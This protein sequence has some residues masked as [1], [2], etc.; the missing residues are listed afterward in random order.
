MAKQTVS[1]A[2]DLIDSMGWATRFPE[3][4]AAFEACETPAQARRLERAVLM[5][6]APFECSAGAA[7]AFKTVV[8]A[9]LTPERVVQRSAADARLATTLRYLATP[10]S[11]LRRR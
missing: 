9:D 5:D 7:Q 8:V 1:E 4:K 6:E 11:N 10:K 2:Q 3:A